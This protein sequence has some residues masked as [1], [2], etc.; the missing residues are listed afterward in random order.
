MS[1]NIPSDNRALTSL[2]LSANKLG[3]TVV[4]EGWSHGYH[5]DYS[6]SKSWKHTDGRR[7]NEKPGKPEGI[8][9]IANAIKDM[10]ALSKLV[11]RRNNIYGAEAA[12]AFATMLT[13]NT[14]LRELDLSSQK[15]GSGGGALDAAFAKEFAVGIRDNRAMTSLNLASNVLGVE[16]ARIIAA[17]V[18]KCT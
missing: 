4:P 16:G 9:A 2:N 13:Q 10:R 6:G 8:I 3:E 7:Q 1:P 14:V 11:M 5:G 12:K 17:S 15:V 18:P